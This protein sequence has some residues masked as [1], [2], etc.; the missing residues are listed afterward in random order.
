MNGE[1]KTWNMNELYTFEE[2]KQMSLDIQVEYINHIIET[3]SVGLPSIS[4][5]LLKKNE[6]Y[7]TDYA[8]K[9]GVKFNKCVPMGRNAQYY[10]LKFIEAIQERDEED[11]FIP[12]PEVI[13]K[14]V[15]KTYDILA[16]GVVKPAGP[17]VDYAELIFR[18]GIDYAALNAIVSKFTDDN[19]K[20]SIRIQ[21]ED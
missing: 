6:N 8:K 7:L 19:Y 9:N 16:T 4:A 15:E 21:K 2:F 20:I 1:T 17:S 18:G 10:R 14:S 11:L 13:K 3:Y 5:Y 12:S